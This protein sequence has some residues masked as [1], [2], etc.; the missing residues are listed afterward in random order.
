M[1]EIARNLDSS[2]ICH[3]WMSAFL[4]WRIQRVKRVMWQTHTWVLKTIPK[5][6]RLIVVYYWLSHIT[7]HFL[8]CRGYRIGEAQVPQQQHHFVREVGR[9]NHTGNY[10]ASGLPYPNDSLEVSVGLEGMNLWG[11]TGEVFNASL[12]RSQRNHGGCQGCFRKM[13][14]IQEVV[15]GRV[16]LTFRLAKL[17]TSADG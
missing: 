12:E 15:H 10:Q 6:G 7:W 8:T 17:Q 9:Q 11:H 4:C 14:I 2:I 13:L 5:C 3:V 16:H 1:G